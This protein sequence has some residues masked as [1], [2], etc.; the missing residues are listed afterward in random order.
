MIIVSA[1]WD[2]MAGTNA[3]AEARGQGPGKG[4]GCAADFSIG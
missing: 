1:A 2:A 4:G 3:R